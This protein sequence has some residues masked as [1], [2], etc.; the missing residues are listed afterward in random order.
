MR[1]FTYYVNGCF[2]P[3]EEGALALNDLGVVRGYGVFDVLRTYGQSP[4]R[5]RHHVLRLVRSAQHIDLDLPWSVEEIEAVVHQTMAR[6]DPSDVTIRIIATG[7]Q[8]PNFIAPQERPSLAVLLAPLSPANPL[9][10]TQGARLISVEMERFMPAVKSLNYVAAIRAQKR[11]RAAGVVE[12]L[13]RDASGRVSECTTSNFFI[14]RGD[15]LI[16]S[17]VDVLAGIT[18]GAALEIGE[19]LFQV[20]VRPIHYAELA[21]ADEA[22][23]TSTTKEIMPVVQVDD[24]VI[25]VGAVGAATRRMMETFHQLVSMETGFNF[26]V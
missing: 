7:G 5:L 13:Y 18:R 12:A 17:D 3:A 2:V 23:I 19:D 11:A 6:N 26:G 9:H 20:E 4:F 16:T 8:S 22:F 25:G 14:F 1:T 24:V 21:L 15:R 10:F